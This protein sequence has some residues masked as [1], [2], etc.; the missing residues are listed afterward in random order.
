MQESSTAASTAEFE[1][2][3]ETATRRLTYRGEVLEVSPLT[4]GQIPALTRT[5]RPIIAAVA[6]LL[7]PT[8]SDGAIRSGDEPLKFDGDGRNI[9]INFEK[10]T[11]LVGDHGE[12]MMSAAAVAVR[13]ERKFIEEGN[14]V[15]FM[16]LVRVIVEVNGDF[17]AR[18][19]PSH[20]PAL[21]PARGE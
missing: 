7:T 12:A 18:A 8:L 15:E 21:Q 20:A 17:F 14:L 11:S 19:M 10:L 5:I 16:D 1:R 9:E 6:D 3:F 13:K 4:V 2:V